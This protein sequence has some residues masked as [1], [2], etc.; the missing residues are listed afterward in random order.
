MIAVDV[1]GLGAG[2]VDALN[3]LGEPVYPINSSSKPTTVN[4]EK[5]YYNL[6]S[7][8]WLEAGDKFADGLVSLPEGMSLTSQ[9]TTVR[10]DFV[11]NGRRQVES[12]DEIKKRIGRSPDRG[13]TLVMGLYAIDKAETLDYYERVEAETDRVGR[14]VPLEVERNEYSMN[15]TT[16]YESLGG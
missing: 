7:Q 4:N 3:E 9:L 13:D 2:V 14:G 1:I 15:I 11:S 8:M 16:G 6:R 10:F 12:K 5:K